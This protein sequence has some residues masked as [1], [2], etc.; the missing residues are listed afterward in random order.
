VK[1][2]RARAK[3]AE[4]DEG[5][6]W[7][8]F[9]NKANDT[10]RIDLF[11]EIGFFGISAKDFVNELNSVDSKTL[12]VHIN[13]PGGGVWDGMAIYNALKNHDGTVNVS[14][15][16]V[17]ASA[18]SFIA[19]AGDTVTMNSAS[20]L[21]L[22]DA[23]GLAIGNASDMQDMAKRLGQMS[24][25]IAE[26]YA[27]K[28]GGT[29]EEWRALMEEE[30][31]YSADEALEAGLVDKVSKNK[32]KSDEAATAKNKFD[33][34]VFNHAGRADAPAP[35]NF[36]NR[37]TANGE[38]KNQTD[39]V[40]TNGPEVSSMTPEQLQKLNLPE[41]ATQEQIDAAFN[42]VVE[43]ASKE[44]T[45]EASKD[46]ST[47]AETKSE[48]TT[49]E[50]ESQTETKTAENST[51]TVSVD[52]EVFKTMKA[53]LEALTEKTNKQ[54]EEKRIATRDSLVS[55]CIKDGR[56][57]PARAEHYKNLFDLDAEGTTERLNSLEKGLIPVKEIGHSEDV[58]NNADESSY[59]TNLLSPQER[60]RLVAAG[61]LSE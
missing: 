53:Q 49:Q 45:T 15:D 52:E 7:F 12:D 10:T 21:M 59:D 28:S 19:C 13:S 23:W 50:S 2:Y 60:K 55:A 61:R 38:I 44:T 41:D 29:V 46:A 11:D 42:A 39:S 43:A 31:W 33:L 34:S 30:T 47:D 17:A 14:I 20:E 16:G 8:K 51:G 26:I 48:S 5:R 54:D 18:A 9:Q 58:Q 32:R 6:E 22:H 35:N 56:I 27:D 24:D 37:A 36:A 4:A 57:P 40:F 3:M 25:T 1:D